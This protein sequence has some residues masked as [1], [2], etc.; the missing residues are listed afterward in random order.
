MPKPDRSAFEAAKAEFEAAKDAFQ[1]AVQ[2]AEAQVEAGTLT[3]AGFKEIVAAELAE[4]KAAKEV[5]K[6]VVKEH[7]KPAKDKKPKPA[8]TA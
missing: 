6:A 1:T 3:E 8:P 7:H 2:E 4:F 5:W